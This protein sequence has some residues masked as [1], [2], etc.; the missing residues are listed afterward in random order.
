M[1]PK[2]SAI[3]DEEII[4]AILN[5]STLKAAAAAVG[6]S[7]R[8]LYD[9]MNSGDFQV[10]YKQARTD[11]LRDA[12]ATLN[13]HIQ[14]AINVIA[15][16]MTDQELNA[17]TRLQAAQTILSNAQKFSH[18]LQVEE[19]IVQGQADSNRLFPW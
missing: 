15:E 16:I 7:E 3:S 13:G 17:A 10:L 14:D 4:T 1:K 5:N 9:R 19:N 11:V 12:V 8:A 2:Q 6:I 18:R